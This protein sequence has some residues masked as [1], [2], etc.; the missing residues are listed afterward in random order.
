M[1]TIG[2][3]LREH[4]DE[5]AVRLAGMLD[6]PVADCRLDTPV[7]EHCKKIIDATAAYL[8][9]IEETLPITNAALRREIWWLARM[10]M[11]VVWSG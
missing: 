11:T 2:K 4:A 7:G 8:A 3:Y 9:V 1:T 5:D 6:T 10:A